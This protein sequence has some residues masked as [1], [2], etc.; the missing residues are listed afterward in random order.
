MRER[1]RLNWE[2]GGRGG[3]QQAAGREAVGVNK[4]RFD[5]CEK[6][7]FDEGHGGA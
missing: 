2:I 5:S 1:K 7:I 4:R 6:G 3:L